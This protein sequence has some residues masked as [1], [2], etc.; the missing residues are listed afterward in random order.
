MSQFINITDC[1]LQKDACAQTK[2]VNFFPDRP[3]CV[4]ITILS[5]LFINDLNFNAF[6][7]KHT[8]SNRVSFTCQVVSIIKHLN[9]NHKTFNLRFKIEE[10]AYII[11]RL[12]KKQ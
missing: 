8:E 7:L 9:I 1:K 11:F 6:S 2:R 10:I 4:S 12:F 3:T 5:T